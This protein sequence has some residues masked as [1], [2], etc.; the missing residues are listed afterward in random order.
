MRTPLI[1]CLLVAGLALAGCG[2]GQNTPEGA[3][4]AFLEA[5]QKGDGE[6][7]AKL[8]DYVAMARVANPDWDSIPEGQ[9]GLIVKKVAEDQARALA[10]QIPQM[11]QIYQDA[12][13]G[14]VIENGETAT[15]QLTGPGS[16]P[17][18]N[19]VNRDGKWLL[20][21]GKIE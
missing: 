18:L 7:V 20:A 6:A 21:G 4:Q 13:T 5:V 1:S 12:Q 9:R 3:A 14:N 15:V 11:Q 17:A 16:P 2:G 10:A 8:Y 19:L